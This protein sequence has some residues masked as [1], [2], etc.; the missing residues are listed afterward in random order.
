MGAYEVNMFSLTVSNGTGSGSYVMGEDVAITAAAPAAGMR[1]DIWTGDT[2]HVANVALESTTLL[3]PE[4]NITVAATYVRFEIPPQT[5]TNLL[6]IGGVETTDH[7]PLLSWDDP[8]GN[9]TWFRVLLAG[10]GGAVVDD[11]TQQTTYQV[12]PDH[13]V[14]NYRWWVYSWNPYGAG[15]WTGPAS[16]AITPLLPG[17][18]DPSV[19]PTGMQTLGERHPQFF[20]QAAANAHWYHISVNRV[21]EGKYVSK[22]VQAPATTWTFDVD[23]RGGNYRWWIAGWNPDGYGAWSSGIDFSIPTMQPG[24]CRLLSPTGG[25]AVATGSVTCRWIPDPRARWY[26]L[27]CGLNG[28]NVVDKWYESSSIVHHGAATSIPGHGWGDY[29]WYVRGWGPDGMGPWSDAGAFVC[30]QPTPV[31]GDASTLMWDDSQTA[32]AEWYQVWIS[33]VTG[34]GAV[35]ERAW[36][37]QRTETSDAGGAN[38]SMA[39]APVL[40]TGNYEWSIRAHSSANGTGPWSDAQGTVVP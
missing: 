27:W 28:G 11:W 29:A 30:G 22:W 39:L 40:A 3:M 38:R 6:P 16:F 24:Q 32:D 33:D 37:F 14:G 15:G 36:W 9:A 25:V 35:K 4:S 18:I 31:S 17:P 10:P 19:G 21:G 13:P 26:Q 8:L 5:P 20:W 34:G 23:F 2:Q 1:F 12:T 7:T